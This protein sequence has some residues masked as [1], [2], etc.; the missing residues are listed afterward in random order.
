MSAAGSASFAGVSN[1][2]VSLKVRARGKVKRIFVPQ[3][4]SFSSHLMHL[5]FSG[6]ASLTEWILFKE[7]ME[8]VLLGWISSSNRN[9]ELS[10]LQACK[11]PPAPGI[12]YCLL[13]RRNL[14][15]LFVLISSRIEQE[16]PV[17]MNM[18]LF[19][20]AEENSHVNN[21]ERWPKYW[22]FPQTLFQRQRL[23]L[24]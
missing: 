21:S 1:K 8:K 12:T 16:Q 4:L 13:V 10:C 22:F 5:L 14:K 3:T 6:E 17:P 20:F 7:V 23:K 24:A 9:F 15:A 2:I 11:K 19:D 18:K